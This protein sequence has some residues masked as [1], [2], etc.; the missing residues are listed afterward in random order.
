MFTAEQLDVTLIT[1]NR[2]PFLEETLKKIFADDSP[3]KNCS[4]TVYDNHSNDGSKEVLEEYASRYANL[5][6]VFSPRNIGLSGNICKALINASKEY[7]WVLCDNDEIKWGNWSGVEKGLQ[8]GHD[9][10]LASRFYIASDTIPTVGQ[11]LAQLTF[12]PSGIYKTKYLTDFVTAWMV[13]DTF[14]ILPHLVL[15]CQIVNEGAD[16][17]VP[18]E[19]VVLMKEN[20]EL[21]ADKIL[22]K[23]E[24]LDRTGSKKRHPKANFYCFESCEVNACSILDNKQYCREM[25]DAFSDINKLNGWGPCFLTKRSLRWY[26]KGEIAWSNLMDI[27][28]I[29]TG[30]EKC[31]FW[32]HYIRYFLKYKIFRCK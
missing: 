9:I 32:C 13:N 14:T 17:Y 18:E 31:Q 24:T 28:P 12:L 5:K 7:V 26:V 27:Y 19:S 2:K 8:E 1:F 16:I 21:Q 11:K 25:I 4:V 3:I 23:A 20:P 22:E 29:L 15:A 30:K 10:V 6:A